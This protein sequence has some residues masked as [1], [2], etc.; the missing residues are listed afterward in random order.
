MA[1]TDDGFVF[2]F[3][4]GDDTVQAEGRK[5]EL[6]SALS[7]HRVYDRD[8]WVM[9]EKATH[10]PGHPSFEVRREFCAGAGLHSELWK[11]LAV[12]MICDPDGETPAVRTFD[13][14]GKATAA[15]SCPDGVAAQAVEG[16]RRWHSIAEYL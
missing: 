7:E 15:A 10:P 11:R 8:G 1:D 6:G 5:A 14:D 9:Q 2:Y 13:V 3:L 4:R 12:N 16:I